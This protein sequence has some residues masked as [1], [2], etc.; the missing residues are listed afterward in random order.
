M[1]QLLWCHWL[2]NADL[3]LPKRAVKEATPKWLPLPLSPRQSPH[4]LHAPN[5]LTARDSRIRLAVVVGSLYLP[6]LRARDGRQLLLGIIPVLVEFQFAPRSDGCALHLLELGPIHHAP[7]TWGNW[8]SHGM[9][10]RL[11]LT[12]AYSPHQGPPPP[13]H[14]NT[15][16]YR[17]ALLGLLRCTNFCPDLLTLGKAVYDDHTPPPSAPLNRPLHQRQDVA[18]PRCRGGGR[19]GRRGVH[20]PK[21]AL[22]S[23]PDAFVSIWGLEL[24]PLHPPTPRAPGRTGVFFPLRIQAWSWR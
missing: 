24:T 20:R 17:G 6:H 5:I 18:C 1:I 13:R 19:V 21:Q 4:T 8:I 7:C 16:E 12:W 14:G 10:D 2:P 11:L 23:S 9:T 15:V 3:Q 22:L